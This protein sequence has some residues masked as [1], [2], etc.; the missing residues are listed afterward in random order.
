MRG[1]PERHEHIVEHA[2]VVELVA[3]LQRLLGTEPPPEVVRIG[4]AAFLHIYALM[5]GH[6]VADKAMKACQAKPLL[7]GMD[8]VVVIADVEKIVPVIE[9]TDLDQALCHARYND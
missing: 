5:L 7:R 2:V 8:I 6:H 1:Y 9:N 3:P 4:N